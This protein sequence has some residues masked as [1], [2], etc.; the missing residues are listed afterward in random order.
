MNLHS[1]LAGQGII[2]FHKFKACD[3][4]GAVP[5]FDPSN[6]G[7][8]SN[9]LPR[10]FD[11]HTDRFIFLYRVVENHSGPVGGAV[12]NRR[13]PKTGIVPEGQDFSFQRFT[14][15][16]SSIKRV[17]LGEFR[18][19]ISEMFGHGFTSVSFRGFLTLFSDFS[20]A[21]NVVFVTF[22]VNKM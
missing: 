17:D 13:A 2:E 20:I 1:A 18:S 21:T 12:D 11:D 16:A 19:G 6:S 15:A 4:A 7:K 3:L 9:S 22:Q 10:G 14:R 5:L 8:S